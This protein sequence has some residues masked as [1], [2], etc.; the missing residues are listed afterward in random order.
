MSSSPSYLIDSDVLITAKNRYYAF[1]ICP[2]FWE[3][4]LHYHRCGHLHSVDQ[5]RQELLRGREDD[6]LVQWV[7]Q[8]VPAGFFLAS[9]DDKIVSAYRRVISWVMCH[10]QYQDE[11]KTQF[12]SGA[13][14]WLVAHGIVTGQT[15][16]TNEQPRPESRNVIKLPD[17]CRQFEVGFEDTFAMLHQIGVQYHY[18][19]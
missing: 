7:G 10:Q 11:A 17:V 14:G 2:G 1:P 13:D 3:S 19:R 5:V 16:V 12:A 6:D 15:V 9:G 18:S 4:V 8:S